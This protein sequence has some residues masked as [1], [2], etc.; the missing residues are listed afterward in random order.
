MTL[1][2]LILHHVLLF[3]VNRDVGRNYYLC[4]AYKLLSYVVQAVLTKERN[5]LDAPIK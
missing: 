5:I 1:T 3:T 4:K 2:A